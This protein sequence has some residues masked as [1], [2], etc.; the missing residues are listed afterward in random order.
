M[1]GDLRLED[2]KRWKKSEYDTFKKYQLQ[3][4]DI[5][6]AMD[7]PWVKAGLKCARISKIVLPALLVQ[8]TA[9]LRNKSK[10]DNSFLYYLIKS[11]AFL[12]HLLDAQT[13]I[14]VPHISGQQILDFKFHLPPLKK[15]QSIVQKLNSL[16]AQTKKLEAIYQQKIN[17]LEELK[18]SILQKAF[19]GELKTV[20][21]L[22]V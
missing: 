10:I 7:R 21:M 16:S 9:C 20:E 13:G 18:K 2:V 8:R 11:R 3:E 5:L 4:N 22:A 14:G 1:Q 6:L 15:Q 12:D 19:S 17:D